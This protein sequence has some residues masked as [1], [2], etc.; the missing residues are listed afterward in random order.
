MREDGC[1]MLRHS[2]H[3]AEASSS[4][5]A[6]PTPDGTEVRPEQEREHASTLPAHFSKAQAE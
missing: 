2:M 5:A 1:V 3:G 4:R 6:L